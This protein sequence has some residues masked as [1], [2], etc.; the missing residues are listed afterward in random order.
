MAKLRYKAPGPHSRHSSLRRKRPKRREQVHPSPASFAARFQ[1]LR[2]RNPL[3][4]DSLLQCFAS[5]FLPRPGILTRD[6]CALHARSKSVA[7]F[8]RDASDILDTNL[9]LALQRSYPV[10][11]YR[12]SD[13]ANGVALCTQNGSGIAVQLGC[14]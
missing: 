7:R 6:K 10:I 8:T 2:V 4:L 5:V 11:L 13:T 3:R 1:E 9:V 12:C 14:R